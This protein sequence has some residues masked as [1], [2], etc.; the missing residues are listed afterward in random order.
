MRLGVFSD[1][2]GN[3]ESFGKIHEHLLRETCDQYLFLG[4][5][6]GYYYRQNEIIDMLR[7]MPG[8]ISITGNHD[9]MFLAATEN[10]SQMMFYTNHF[11][12]SFQL[13]RETIRRENLD[14]LK[15]LPE[16]AVV[17]SGRIA[18]FHGSPW[19]P[20]GE[21][22]Y[23]DSMLE[24]FQELP[25]K[26]VFLG[27]THYSMDRTKDNIRVINPGSAGQPR[28]GRLP[29]FAIFDTVSGDLKIKHIQFDIGAQIREVRRWEEKNPYLITVLERLEGQE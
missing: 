22:V 12:K 28:N 3:L 9:A 25:Y 14:Y 19:N 1:I 11:G 24:G 20:L 10:E 7:A 17:D 16:R 5:V 21:Y 2:H 23:P 8:L 29:S 27:H 15:S 18:L 4:D 6:C 26:V 13:L